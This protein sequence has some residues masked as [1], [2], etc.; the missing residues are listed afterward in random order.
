MFESTQQF[1]LEVSVCGSA[2]TCPPHQSF[3]LSLVFHWPDLFHGI[4]P[5]VIVYWWPRQ[6]WCYRRCHWF[7]ARW[8]FRMGCQV[9]PERAWLHESK[10]QAAHGTG[11]GRTWLQLC[12]KLSR[13]CRLSF[14][15][16]TCS[17]RWCCWTRRAQGWRPQRRKWWESRLV[18]AD[19]LAPSRRRQRRHHQLRRE[20]MWWSSAWS[21]PVAQ[22]RWRRAQDDHAFGWRACWLWSMSSWRLRSWWVAPSRNCW[23]HW[24]WWCWACCAAACSKT[25]AWKAAMSTSGIVKLGTN[26]GVLV[27]LTQQTNIPFF[28]ARQVEHNQLGVDHQRGNKVSDAN[29][30]S[31]RDIAAHFRTNNALDKNKLHAFSQ[32]ECQG[33]LLICIQEEARRIACSAMMTSWRESSPP[34]RGPSWR[35]RCSS[36][37]RW[38]LAPTTQLWPDCKRCAGKTSWT[39]MLIEFV[40][41]N[42]HQILLKKW[43]R[44]PLRNDVT[45]LRAGRE[46]AARSA[47]RNEKLTRNSCSK[48]ELGYAAS[49][50][51]QKQSADESQKTSTKR[52]VTTCSSMTWT[53]S[54]T[55][56]LGYHLHR[57]ARELNSWSSGV[58]L[59]LDKCVKIVTVIGLVLCSRLICDVLRNRQSRNVNVARDT[60]ISQ[61]RRHPR[62]TPQFESPRYRS[63]ATTW[64]RCRQIR[65][66]AAWIPSAQWYDPFRLD[67]WRRGKQDCQAGQ[68]Q[69]SC[70]DCIRVLD[71]RWGQYLQHLRG[72]VSLLLE[73]TPWRRRSNKETTSQVSRRARSWVRCETVARAIDVRKRG[74]R[75]TDLSDSENNTDN[76]SAASEQSDDDVCRHEEEQSSDDKSD[77]DDKD[78]EERDAI[79][80]RGRH[81][82][83]DNFMKKVLSPVIGYSEDYEL[84]HFVYDLIMWTSLDK[85]KNVTRGIPLRLTVKGASCSPV[86]WRARHLALID[87]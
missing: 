55:T 69:R 5:I 21:L 73:E 4:P 16:S 86:Y 81:S 46:S 58:N 27:P 80:K 41:D 67:W 77:N 17:T 14:W 70:R 72:K 65:A 2:L 71:E 43:R 26:V 32:R 60:I 11:Q 40:A 61:G 66:R 1:V 76:E 6:A 78:D 35:R 7:L 24:T 56:T 42:G 8:R 33:I 85:C 3:T 10:D 28:V 12:G 39:I 49:S 22:R 50:T 44:R 9:W 45:F 54:Q 75:C 20:R 30:Q 64:H 23:T 83:K 15:C 18:P 36:F 38:P 87:M 52:S 25:C 74:A 59:D 48:T 79:L 82:M 63:F 68:G 47:R 19:T 13:R 57:S 51:C 62:G 37:R 53:T 34:R 31:W 29:Q 84:L